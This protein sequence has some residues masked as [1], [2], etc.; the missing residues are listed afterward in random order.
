MKI[1][2]QVILSVSLFVKKRMRYDIQVTVD[3]SKPYSS[4]TTGI[5]KSVFW[6]LKITLRY[7]YFNIRG[8]EMYIDRKISRYYSI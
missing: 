7:Q 8:A 3:I 1:S 4:Q 6:S 5:S 2:Q